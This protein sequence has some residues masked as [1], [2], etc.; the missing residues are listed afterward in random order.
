MPTDMELFGGTMMSPV[1]DPYTVYRR[2]RREQPV[3]CVEGLLGRDHLVTRY[4]DVLAILKNPT[5]FS[6]R[7]NAR[8]AGLVMG[9]T[10]LEMDGREHLRHRTLITPF[11]APSALRGGV[12]AMIEA[13]VHHL[14]D[15]FAA[16][17]RADL[18]PQFTF[19]FPMRV[20]AHIIGIPIDDYATFHHWAVDLL[21]IGDD[22]EK[23]FAASAWLVDY[24]R[25][26]LDQR[27][28]EPDAGLLSALLHTE[29][30]GHRLTDEEVLSFLRLLLPAGAETTYRLLGSTLF[31]LLTHTDQ[32]E[33]VQADRSKLDLA[34]EETL[35]WEAPIQYVSRETTSAATVAGIDI[36]AGELVS[37]ALGSAN[38]DERHFE[39]PDQFD[40]HRRLDDHVAFGLGPHF[41]P[42]S[43]LARAE[44]R[45]ALG[46]LLDRLPNLRLDAAQRPQVVGLA[47]RSP[48]RL[49]VLFD[50]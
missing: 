46:A 4:D 41:C 48:D 39:D 25:P 26:I 23:G 38:R 14:I 8:A 42:G 49:P 17:G 47:L 31:G 37:A 11:F 13:T 34:I 5:L 18:V 7:A 3:I 35:R 21:R 1:V 27:R 16:D 19:T 28:A 36:P 50:P 33:E 9:R 6:S 40:L 12:E 44:A 32:L 30:D 45:I 10:I 22:P 29:V 43:H 24:L 15:Q 20:I 2:L